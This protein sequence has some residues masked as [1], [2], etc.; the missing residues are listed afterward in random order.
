MSTIR[1]TLASLLWM[2]PLC[3]AAPASLGLSYDKRANAMPTLTLPYATYQASDY[4]PDGEASLVFLDE[5]LL[6]TLLL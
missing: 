2:V 1:Y 4:N 3:R 5:I 6:L